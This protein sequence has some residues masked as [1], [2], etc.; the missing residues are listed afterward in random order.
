M[1]NKLTIQPALA[2]QHFIDRYTLI[3]QS[4]ILLGYNVAITLIN[5]HMVI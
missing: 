5:S 4:N 2:I 1:S 3:E